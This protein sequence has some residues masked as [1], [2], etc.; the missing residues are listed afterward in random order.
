MT[1]RLHIDPDPRNRLFEKGPWWEYCADA[2]CTLEHVTYKPFYPITG[3]RID[4]SHL[5]PAKQND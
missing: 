2:D 5:R 3:Q 4:L 1:W